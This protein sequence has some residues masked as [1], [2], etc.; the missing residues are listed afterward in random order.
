M[1]ST[2]ASVVLVHVN[3][4]LDCCVSIIALVYVCVV[5]RV[6]HLL[7]VRFVYF[8]HNVLELVYVRTFVGHIANNIIIRI[9]NNE[10]MYGHL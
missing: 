6:V 3:S 5:V 4:P 1:Q 8:V 9:R 2:L 7:G 10:I